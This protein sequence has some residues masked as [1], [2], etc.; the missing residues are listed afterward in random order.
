MICFLQ[1]SQQGC[2]GRA[3]TDVT[4]EGL[5]ESVRE[6]EKNPRISSKLVRN[7]TEVTEPFFLELVEPDQPQFGY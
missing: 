3:S 5:I 1:L 2:G 7:P 4:L 6:E